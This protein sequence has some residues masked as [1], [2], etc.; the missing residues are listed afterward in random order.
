MYTPSTIVLSLFLALTLMLSNTYAADAATMALTTNI[1]ASPTIVQQTSTT[2]ITIMVTNTT[3]K[4]T[5][6][7]VTLT[8]NNPYTAEVY[9]KVWPKHSFPSNKSVV[10]TTNF[11]T[12]ASSP[13]GTYT[14]AV[15][16]AN[17]RQS[18]RGAT[19]T[20]MVSEMIVGAYSHLDNDPVSNWLRYVE[21][22]PGFWIDDFVEE[23]SDP[24]APSG[25]NTVFHMGI[26]NSSPYANVYRYQ[27][28]PSVNS[29]LF[30]YSMRFKWS[31]GGGHPPEAL[32]FPFSLYTGSHRLEA[33]LQW[34]TGW[35]GQG[36]RW[37]VWAG[38]TA[39]YWTD[40]NPHGQPWNF[41][42]SLAPDVWHSFS[43]SA[44]IQ[45]DQVYYH[46]FTVDGQTFV[47]NATYPGVNNDAPAQ[48][49]VA[50]QIDN[51]WSGNQQDV[52]LDHVTLSWMP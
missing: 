32:E 18:A 3:S 35:D 7:D 31:A 42:Q 48:L 6:S 25:D 8:V 47:V 38:P 19:T 10:L 16:I 44:T 49:V 15:K 50:Y 34:V 4:D 11:A 36:A 5:S 46:S 33:A 39:G 30:T 43:L 13:V 23:V 20:F 12:T 28:K 1:T 41:V 37:R 17:T 22:P 40:T 14:A 45:N 27:S 29:T 21:G 26:T 24:S 2:D 9:R 51:N 52:W